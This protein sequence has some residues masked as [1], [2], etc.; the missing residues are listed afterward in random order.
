MIRVLAGQGVAVRSQPTRFPIDRSD[1]SGH[2]VLPPDLAGRFADQPPVV[3]EA[4]RS[5]GSVSGTLN[6]AELAGL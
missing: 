5:E 3:P 1:I 2:I 4:V 6:A